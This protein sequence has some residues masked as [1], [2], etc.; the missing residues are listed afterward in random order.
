MTATI[1]VGDKISSVLLGDSDPCTVTRVANNG[2]TV[3]VMFNKIGN[4]KLEWPEQD[5]EV[6]DETYPLPRIFTLR[7]NGR[8]VMKGQPMNSYPSLSRQ[9]HYYRDPHI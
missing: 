8:Y 2:K 6:F 9:H 5:F 4:N 7:K 3:E 1:K